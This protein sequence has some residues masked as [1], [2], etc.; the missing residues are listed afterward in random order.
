MSQLSFLKTLSKKANL[1]SSRDPT[2]ILPY[3]LIYLK[4]KMIINK[5]AAMPKG[6]KKFNSGT[7]K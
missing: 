6:A 2:T 3:Y 1:S 4:D 7:S 5:K